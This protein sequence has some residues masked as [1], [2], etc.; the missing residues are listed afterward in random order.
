[1]AIKSGNIYIQFNLGGNIMDE[2]YLVDL[3]HLIDLNKGTVYINVASCFECQYPTEGMNALYSLLKHIDNNLDKFEHKDINKSIFYSLIQKIDDNRKWL[4][5][6][7]E[8]ILEANSKLK[9]DKGYSESDFAKVG[10]PHGSFDITLEELIVFY[11]ILVILQES[12]ED[13]KGHI[14]YSWSISNYFRHIEAIKTM[15]EKRLMYA[16]I[17]SR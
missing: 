14:I 5:E 12:Y 4:H 2:K 10:I 7:N 15:L 9:I 3:R 16:F 13:I 6:L 8:Y 1:M 11:K 17:K